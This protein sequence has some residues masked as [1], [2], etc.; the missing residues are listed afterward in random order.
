LPGP[1]EI[2]VLG[3]VRAI[4]I[5]VIGPDYAIDLS[6]EM[7]TSFD[8]DLGLESIEFVALAERL[9]EQYGR[10]VDFIAW[11]ATKELDEIIALTV[12]E[13]VSFLAISTQSAPA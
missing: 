9:Q 1:N 8:A 4:L 13:L 10:D 6:I 7:D 2:E 11:L 12:G 5:D 3:A